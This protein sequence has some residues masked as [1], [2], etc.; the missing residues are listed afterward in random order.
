MK[1]EQPLYGG[2]HM[3]VNE[4]SVPRMPDVSNVGVEA[5]ER[6]VGRAGAAIA[7]IGEQWQ[8]LKDGTTD[9]E[10]ELKLKQAGE[11]FE[12]EVT[13]GLGYEHGSARSLFDKNGQIDQAKRAKLLDKYN[14]RIREIRGV[15]V[16]PTRADQMERKKEEVSGLLGDRLDGILIKGEIQRG[17][18][19][20]DERYKNAVQQGDYDGAMNL[21]YDAVGRGLLS[22]EAANGQAYQL[23]K[24]KLVINF[25]NTAA[26]DPGA[27]YDL[28]ISN[29]YK[30]TFTPAEIEKMYDQL[31]RDRK[32]NDL[33]RMGGGQSKGGSKK[34]PEFSGVFSAK[35]LGWNKAIR[36][37]RRG[38]VE[39][40]IRRAAINEAQSFSP[41]MGE[42]EMAM[43]EAEYVTRYADVFGLD[44]SWVVQQWKSAQKRREE[45][46][47][48]DYNI[49]TPLNVMFDKGDLINQ[50]HF[51][52]EAWPVVEA[53]KDDLKPGGKIYNQFI[54]TGVGFLPKDTPEDVR[55]KII[56]HLRASHMEGVRDQIMERWINW[57]TTEGKEATINVQLI[58]LLNEVETIT[59][60]K[61]DYRDDWTKIADA[62]LE[63]QKDKQRHNFL[64]WTQHSLR[65][66]NVTGG[67]EYPSIK[68]KVKVNTSQT[69]LSEGVLL[70]EKWREKYPNGGMVRMTLEGRRGAVCL[71]VVGFT[72]GDEI[73]MS[74]GSAKEM[75]IDPQ[76]VTESKMIVVPK[77]DST[78]GNLPLIQQGGGKTAAN[79]KTGLDQYDEVFKLYGG[80]YGI[81]P[82]WLKAIAMVETGRGTSNAFLKKNNAMGVSPN[83]GGPRA[84]GSVEESIEAGAKILARLMKQGYTSIE[85]IGPIW[86]PPGAANDPHGT[87]GTWANQVLACLKELENLQGAQV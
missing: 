6:A 27:A 3:S 16:D 1:N 45:L 10:L 29:S 42:E 50:A 77:V 57:R 71:P 18:Q 26:T 63:Q 49:K 21:L 46:K 35:E 60:K 52:V 64:T 86:A 36:E 2:Q 56:A 44:K 5:A 67:Y 30:Q 7:S 83:G 47:T 58:Q 40:D 81:N 24:D 28:L 82:N 9:D 62:K 69:G 12:N 38:E 75:C 20:F 25:S 43:A 76:K 31:A 53:Q 51:N 8:R 14:K 11:E 70:P 79:G 19:A 15:Y 13:A 84:F 17:R 68:G 74:Y 65:N 72:D 39:K 41:D 22:Q 80:K 23:M 61:S 54:G 85:T 33:D 37:G 34:E 4:R 66:I 32:R 87:N 59:G 73:E 78:G 55:R 48:P